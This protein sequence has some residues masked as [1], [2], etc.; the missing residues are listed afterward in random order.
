MAID[1][2]A[3]RRQIR[4]ER[5]VLGT[6][7]G[8]VIIASAALIVWQ[9]YMGR[10]IA[11]TPFIPRKGKVTPEAELLQRY[12]RID[13]SH[14]NEIDG[15][16]WIG[17]QLDRAHI[18]YEIFEPAPG[19]ANLYAR[20]RGKRRGE[21]LML[22]SHIDVIPASPSGWTR[23]PFSGDIH[24]N[25]IW[26]RGS[27]DMKSIT[28]CQL[29]AFIAVARGGRQPE[30]DIVLLAVAD[31]ET[32]SANGMRW[33]VEHRPDIVDGVRYALNEG[34]VTETLNEQVTYFGIEIGT[35]QVI[36]LD[37]HAPSRE[38]LQKARI[39]LEPWFSP[40]DADEVLPEVARYFHAI[41]PFR[42]EPRREL[43]DLPR[44]VKTGQLWKLPQAYRELT[45][46]VVWASTIRKDGDGWTMRTSLFN[47]P[48]VD[49]AS[50][51]EWLRGKVTPFGVTL[52]TIH[53]NDPVARL[54]SDRSPLFALIAEE[55]RRQYQVDVGTQILTKSIN[56]SR[57]LRPLG[58]LCYGMWPFPVDYYQTQGI[59]GID[60][61]V[62]LD[63]FQDG[64]EMT[65]KIVS[66][67]AFDPKAAGES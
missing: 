50:R 58:I 19:R 60:E 4:R 57:F 15:A 42:F 47:L 23:A 38:Q 22:A 46:N 3:R 66:R 49:G 41:A 7:L 26:G 61:R 48:N 39:A 30:R 11:A 17:Q 25:Q 6:I 27:L 28:V 31:E 67:Y 34:G 5:I 29:E 44:T 36:A 9:A 18:P 55:V 10:Q 56:D 64:V 35:K 53:T 14:Q 65:R 59:H 24:L 63:W 37:L 1:P 2:E 52:G 33:I 12:I 40:T 32:G 43:E 62:R 20:I 45:Q 51:I 8:L 21:G 16:R 54:S 13:T